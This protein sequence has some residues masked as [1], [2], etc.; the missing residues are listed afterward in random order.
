MHPWVPGGK[1]ERGWES[2]VMST[3]L[4]RYRL[5]PAASPSPVCRHGSN[6]TQAGALPAACSEDAP[7]PPG[8]SEANPGCELLMPAAALRCPGTHTLLAA[9][10]AREQGWRKDPWDGE[11]HEGSD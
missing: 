5:N 3:P 4:P 9:G 7:S 11:S 6:G 10:A 1:K 8:G 2:R